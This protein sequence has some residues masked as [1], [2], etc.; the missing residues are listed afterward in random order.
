MVIQNK[1]LSKKATCCHKKLQVITQNNKIVYKVT[2]CHTK[3]QVVIQSKRLLCKTKGNHIKRQVVI[4]NN[5]M[6]YKMASCHTKQKVVIQNER[7]SYKTTRCQTN[8]HVVR[9]NNKVPPMNCY[10]LYMLYPILRHSN[11]R[12]RHLGRSQYSSG[13]LMG[14]MVGC[15]L[16]VGDQWF[17]VVF[18]CMVGAIGSSF[19][20]YL[21]LLKF[22]RVSL[23]HGLYLVLE[24]NRMLLVWFILCLHCIY[25][26]HT[27]H[28]MYIVQIL[29]TI[30]DEGR[31]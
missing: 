6:S 28:T 31:Q 14:S 8:W 7:L 10:M 18:R 26:L 17:M 9:Q 11:F 15:W 27:M 13:V 16:N 2:G 19:E 3:W 29:A 24:R 21:W 12:T 20:G 30:S 22:Q 5:W 4:Q 1:R 25:T 23:V